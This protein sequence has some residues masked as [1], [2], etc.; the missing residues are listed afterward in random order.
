MR[1]VREIHCCSRLKQEEIYQR[2]HSRLYLLL[3]NQVIQKMSDP[4]TCIFLFGHKLKKLR[5]NLII[6]AFGI[7]KEWAVFKY[8]Y[9]LLYLSSTNLVR[10]TS[11]GKITVKHSVSSSLREI[12]KWWNNNSGK[13]KIMITACTIMWA[14][15]SE[16]EGRPA[17]GGHPHPPRL[18]VTPWIT[19]LASAGEKSSRSNN[20]VAFLFF[21]F[22]RSLG[23]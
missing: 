11:V 3:Y 2:F 21:F 23:K 1:H 12:C 22:Q 19:E 16:K 5:I 9:S 13:M 15:A 14:S 4:P 17:S 10:E 18:S 7:S 20:A 8:V 6:T